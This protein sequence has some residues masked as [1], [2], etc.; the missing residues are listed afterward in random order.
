MHLATGHRKSCLTGSIV[1]ALA[2]NARTGHPRFRNGQGKTDLIRMAHRASELPDLRQNL[3][4]PALK[5]AAG[6]RKPKNPGN[7]MTHTPVMA[8][9]ALRQGAV[10]VASSALKN[11]IPTSLRVRCAERF[12]YNSS[13]SHS[14]N[15]GTEKVR[16]FGV[17]KRGLGRRR[18]GLP[19]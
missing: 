7:K 10:Q 12:T 14:Q 9:D 2:K 17:P 5:L 13:R 8:Y 16:A 19:G 15:Q 3:G 1:P 6:P 18:A 4:E 11:R